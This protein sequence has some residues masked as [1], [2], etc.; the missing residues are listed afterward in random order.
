MNSNILKFKKL[1]V[2]GS[3]WEIYDSFERTNRFKNFSARSAQPREN[4]N[5]YK[6][7]WRA[8]RGFRLL[9]KCNLYAHNQRPKFLTL[10]FS[11]NVQDLKIANHIF[12]NFI[13]RFNRY[14]GF[15]LKY[16][17][18]PE[19]QKSGRVHYHLILF[20]LPRFEPISYEIFKKDL[21]ERLWG[22]RIEFKVC[23]EGAIVYL[24]KYMAKDYALF[25]HK[26]FKRYFSSS[27]L[28]KPIVIENEAVIEQINWNLQSLADR[29]RFTVST[30]YGY[31]SDHEH[32]T[33]PT[34]QLPF[35]REKLALISKEVKSAGLCN[36]R[37]GCDI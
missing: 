25:R 20:N 16:V 6:S 22:G 21:R 14:L 2:A 30:P 29:R 23:D 15:Q 34:A 31:S 10:T 4:R 3:S 33:V 18:V 32:F 35:F 5:V 12:K 28:Y 13:L 7:A 37:F 27:G 17:C 36:L 9:V 24:T 19:F 11:K 26:G 8:L 1:V